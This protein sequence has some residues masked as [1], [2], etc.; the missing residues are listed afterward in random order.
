MRDGVTGVLVPEPSGEAF[1]AAFRSLGT[2][3]F[4]PDV[5]R[6]HAETFSRER[7]ASEMQAV[8]DDTLRAPEGTQ[9]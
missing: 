9:W 8:I 7:F 2:R 4:N 1:A 3:P 6:R 5:I